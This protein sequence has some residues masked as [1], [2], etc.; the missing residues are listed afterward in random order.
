MKVEHLRQFKQTPVV[1]TGALRTKQKKLQRLKAFLNWAR[2]VAQL[3][4]VST[5]VLTLGARNAA[6]RHYHPFT[7]EDLKALFESAD[8]RHQS[9]QRASEFWIP[10]MGLYTG[11]RINELAQLLVSDITEAD[12]VT[13]PC[14]P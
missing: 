12:G 2:D 4:T 1:S 8:Y 6:A 9:F 3:T 10:L 7:L 13:C 11:A 14:R 5:A